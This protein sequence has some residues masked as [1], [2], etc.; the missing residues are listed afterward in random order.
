LLQRQEPFGTPMRKLARLVLATFVASVPAIAQEEV[1]ADAVTTRGPDGETV[2]GQQLGTFRYNVTFQQRPFDLTAF[3]LAIENGATAAQVQA[4]VADLQQRTVQNQAAFVRAI[5]AMGG[6]V[7]IQ[8][9]LID[10]CTI[11]VRPD[12]LAAV[13][14][15]GNVLHVRPD[16]QTRTS[17]LTATDANNHNADAVQAAGIT[18]T[19]YG[20]GIVDTGQD[21]SMNGGSRPHR[22]Y[23]RGGNVA[24][25]TA[26][27]I[28]GSRLLANVQLGAQSADDLNGH[29]TGVAGIAAGEVWAT[30]QADRGHAN[31][32]FVIGYSI[33]QI[34]PGC[35]STLAIEALGWQQ[36][37]ADKVKFNIV[38]VNM[39]YSSSPDPTDISQQA[40]DAAALNADILA[41]ACAFNSGPAVSSTTA[42]S[43]TS[44]GLAVAAC[45]TN[46][47]VIAG[48][49]SRGPLNTDP[50][51]F[52][53]DIT[54]CGVSIAMP[55]RNNET[56]NY[57]GSGTSMAAPQVAGAAALVK[58]ARPASS[59]REIK[60]ILLASTESIAA[61]NAGLDRNAYGL[62]FLRDDSA[63]AMAQHPGSVQSG[64]LTALTTPNVHTLAV[65]GGQT[66]TVCLVFHRQVLTA[67]NYSD[68]SLRVSD[69]A[70]VIA[71]SDDPRNLYERVTFTAPNTGTLLVEVAAASLEVNPLPY[72]MATTA[73]FGGGAPANWVNIGGGC[74]GTKGIPALFPAANPVLGTSFVTRSAYA[75][76]NIFG[77]FL[78]GGSS[79]VWS[80][81]ALPFDLGLIGAPGCL[82]RT[83]VIA[84]DAVLTD[85]DGTAS[86]SYVIPNNPTLVG[87]VLFQQL[88]AY[89]P[90]VNALGFTVSNAGAMTIG[91]F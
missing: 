66:Y 71:S 31:D 47:K 87:A 35:N 40:I 55:R 68:L 72:S 84:I 7:A 37:A 28:G 58:A 41:V 6:R 24:D 11:E 78:I 33:C 79:T 73:T 23:F 45:S 20:V 44:N 91:E 89:D 8:F 3:R 34:T 51:R 5:E 56:A 50:T 2:A 62:G 30:P 16:L 59:A 14:A 77:L 60:A 10:A 54:A 80:G 4:I 36:A 64:E 88:A 74:P 18:A 17:I 49:S 43:A 52:F 48:F 81:G 15:L 19:G 26:G 25:Q 65:V 63:V 27:G 9:W 85:N 12:Q 39:S 61:Q 70:T 13:Q 46:G 21:S 69:G 22:T 90:T 86:Q 42:S 32:A 29:G 1:T 53:P 82:L 38:S 83:D 57:T 76:G 75:P 67:T